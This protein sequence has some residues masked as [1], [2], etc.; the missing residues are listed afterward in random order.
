MELNDRE[1]SLRPLR[2][3]VQRWLILGLGLGLAGLCYA[4]YGL[5][6]AA[7]SES[8]FSDPAQLVG[9][10]LFGVIS[11]I[12]L[13]NYYLSQK[14]AVIHTLEHVIV[15]QKIE[16][17]LNRELAL[18]DPVT[19]VYNRRYLRAVFSRE[20]SRVKRYNS[21]LALMMVDI[22]GFRRVNESLGQAGGDVVLRQVAH[23]IQT[24]I[25]NADTIVRFGDDDFLLVLPDTTEEGVQTL[26]GR[27][28]QAVVEWSRNSGMA[29]F[30]LRFAIGSAQY[31][32]DRRMD[33]ILQL[34]EQRMLRDK[35]NGPDSGVQESRATINA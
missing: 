28:K 5:L 8:R 35:S 24:R 12:V 7:G 30:G 13:L 27:L 4:V 32:A 22:M 9:P 10:L 14:H 3:D 21:A 1:Q 33:E 18:V 25:R 34:A 31:S 11:L 15:R 19:E 29:D 17:E 23:L 20:I 16:A 26:T 6:R 2:R